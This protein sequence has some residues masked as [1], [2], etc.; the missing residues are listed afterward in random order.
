MA[1]AGFR[2]FNYGID[3]TGGTLIEINTNKYIPTEELRQIT[4]SF[5][6]GM[7]INYIGEERDGVQLKTTADLN[8]EKR[9]E[10]FGEFSSKYN[11]TQK[12]LIKSEQFGPSI[13]KE[14]KKNRK[15][16]YSLVSSSPKHSKR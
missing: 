6:P 4:D 8:N 5:D 11:L 1:L 13:G 3:F 14:I 12:D 9:T 2:G 15:R 16:K 10:L 7:Q